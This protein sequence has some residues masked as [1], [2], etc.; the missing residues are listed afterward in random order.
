MAVA[1]AA[2]VL[3]CAGFGQ[4]GSLTP[5]ADGVWSANA[6]TC[7]LP[8]RLAATAPPPDATAPP[9]D[10]TAPPPDA[11]APPPDATASP[12]DATAS[13]PDAT[14]SPPDVTACSL[15]GPVGSGF[16]SKE[17]GYPRIGVYFADCPSAGHDMLC[18][19]YRACGPAGEPQVV[20]IDQ[21]WDYA[22]V[23]VA[24]TFEAFIRG[25]ED[26]SAFEDEA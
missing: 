20:H 21:E 22:I 9:P 26:D 10:V 17:W 23:A 12:P 25:L 18:L 24:E 13:P 5:S 6:W 15:C 2:G 3:V 14:A 4:P 16:W 1:A 7:G 11:T 19:D 8:S